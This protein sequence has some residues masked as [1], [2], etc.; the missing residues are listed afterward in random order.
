MVVGGGG[1]WVKCLA[2]G[3]R[4]LSLAAGRGRGGEGRERCWVRPRLRCQRHSTPQLKESE[5]AEEWAEQG[6]IV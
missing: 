5:G 3:R 1:K 6:K 4:E 2:V